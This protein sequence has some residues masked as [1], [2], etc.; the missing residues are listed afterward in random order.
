MTGRDIPELK[1]LPGKL[2]F[3][4]A[5]P[6]AADPLAYAPYIPYGG[7]YIALGTLDGGSGPGGELRPHLYMPPYN[8]SV[9]ALYPEEAYNIDRK[10]DDGMPLTG[11]V[12]SARTWDHPYYWR[13]LD[14]ADSSSYCTS[15][16]GTYRTDYSGSPGCSLMIK[17]PY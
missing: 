2:W 8:D 14:R 7:H 5:T 10:L 17:A 4:T 1:I 16:S 15:T 12:L 9:S 11:K 6:A 3:I 13:Q